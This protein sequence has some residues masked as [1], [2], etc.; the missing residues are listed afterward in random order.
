MEASTILVLAR[1]WGLRA[2]GMAVVLDDMLH[3][4]DHDSP[5]DP[6]EQLIHSAAYIE[7]I[8]TIGC[9]AVYL[10]GNRR[11]NDTPRQ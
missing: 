11:A 1:I 7:R 8:S 10:L 4:S 5:F 6:E 9:E 3:V 2:G